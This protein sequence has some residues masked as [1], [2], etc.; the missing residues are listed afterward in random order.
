MNHDHYPYNTISA[1]SNITYDSGSSNTSTGYAQGRQGPGDGVTTLHD[2]INE[3]YEY[4]SDTWSVD[5]S[6][7][8]EEDDSILKSMKIP[9]DTRIKPGLNYDIDSK[10]RI[11]HIPPTMIVVEIGWTTTTNRKTRVRRPFV[12]I[13]GYTN[14]FNSDLRSETGLNLGKFMSSTHWSQK[15]DD[16]YRSVDDTNNL[17]IFQEIANKEYKRERHTLENMESAVIEMLY[18]QETEMDKRGNDQIHIRVL[19][20]EEATDLRDNRGYSRWKRRNRTIIS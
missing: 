17:S 18:S 5:H 2:G 16:L 6:E 8:G 11:Y 9:E 13:S 10:N 20:T 1:Q 14:T 4:D 12:D 19:T 15:I 3:E 7:G